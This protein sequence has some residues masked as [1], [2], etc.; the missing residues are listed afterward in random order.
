MTARRE[1]VKLAFEYVLLAVLALPG[2]YLWLPYFLPEPDVEPVDVV[3]PPEWV[4]LVLI[5]ASPTIC[6]VSG[7]LVLK[8]RR[9]ARVPRAAAMTLDFAAAALWAAIQ[10]LIAWP[11]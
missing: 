6:F 2:L 1:H 4:F 10:A 3:I 9:V 11:G 8:L 5:Y 7:L